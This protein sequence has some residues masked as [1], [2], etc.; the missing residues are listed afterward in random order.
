M[1]ILTKPVLCYALTLLA[2]VQAPALRAQGGIVPPGTIYFTHAGSTWS[3]NGDGSAKIP[4]PAGVSGAPSH[5]LHGGQR[6]FLQFQAVSG[7]YPDNSQRQELFVVRGDGLY[8]IQLTM[9]A[10]L[11]PYPLSPNPARWKFDDGQVS[12][13]AARWVGTSLTAPG[14]YASQILFDGSGNVVGLASQP[15]SA[16]VPGSLVSQ[17]ST[18]RPDISAHDW[19]PDNIRLVYS[20]I[21]D[22]A[23]LRRLYIA[24]TLTSG[25]PLYLP[26][27]RPAGSPSWSPAGTKIL[28]QAA[29]FSGEIY[30]ISADGTGEKRLIRTH[31]GMINGLFEPHWSQNGQHIL[32]GTWG[33]IL[34]DERQ[35]TY[36]AKADGSGRT[37]LTSSLDTRSLSGSP[38]RP[39]E[40]R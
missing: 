19:S 30:S 10:D 39:V 40:W 33:S 6:W 32:Y 29:E 18:L 11:K 9:Q 3:M 28:F 8:G 21:S 20:T 25:S 22:T 35:D 12:W 31:S 23:S 2:A 16:L 37:N 13:V 4:L 24:N 26:T 5:Q 1:R 38:A 7:T 34:G 15:M 27:S 14:I 36:R 17:N